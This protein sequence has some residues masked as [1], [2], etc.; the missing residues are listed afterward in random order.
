MCNCLLQVYSQVTILFD[1]APDLL[2]EFSQFLPGA[3]GQQGSG[4]L[5]SGDLFGGGGIAP[6]GAQA[7]PAPQAGAEKG[8]RGAKAEKEIKEAAAPAANAA[9]G[10]RKKRAADKDGKGGAR[11]S[12][13]QLAFSCV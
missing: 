5:F 4:G 2:E 7:A 9:G 13:G 1:N 10:S 8:K 12:R 3:D 11:V 6:A